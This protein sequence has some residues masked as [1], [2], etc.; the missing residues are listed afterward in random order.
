[1]GSMTE[2]TCFKFRRFDDRL[3]DALIKST[4]YFPRQAQL[5]DPFD[6]SVDIFRTIDHAINSGRCELAELLRR[7]RSDVSAIERFRSQ[8]AK[9]G[10]GSFS[11]T[12]EETM[13]WSHYAIYLRGVALLFE[14]AV[15]M[16]RDVDENILGA[17]LV[18]FD[19]IAFS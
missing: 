16:V 10:V 2:F 9:M 17:S 19:P 11:T 13:L 7:I 5:K 4:V 6:C 8:V 15:V 3:G 18:S 12:I 14:F 1:M